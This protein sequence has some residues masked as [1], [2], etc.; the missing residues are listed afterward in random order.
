MNTCSAMVR[1]CGRLERARR[2]Q[3]RLRQNPNP[4]ETEYRKAREVY[5]PNPRCLEL[6]NYPS[7]YA[8]FLIKQ[9][10]LNRSINHHYYYDL[11]INKKIF[12]QE[13]FKYSVKLKMFRAF[14]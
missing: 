8:I 6:L 2:N 12:L 14:K 9:L 3:R 10:H 5:K 4:A 1:R 7:F 13:K 11:N